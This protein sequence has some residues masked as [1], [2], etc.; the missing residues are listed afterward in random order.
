M[1]DPYSIIIRPHIT[2]KTMDLSLGDD[3]LKDDEIVRKYTFV[4]SPDANKI[5]IKAAIETIYNT[6]KGKK[7]ERIVVTNV[8][9]ISV[10]GKMRRVGYKSRGKRPDWKKAVITLAPGQRLEDYAV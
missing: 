10:K 8:S 6:G 1:N 2:E 5:Q 7:D 9:T 4:V 3:R